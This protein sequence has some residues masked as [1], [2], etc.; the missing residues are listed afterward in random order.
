MKKIL[1]SIILLLAVF[2]L[3]SC[4]KSGLVGTWVCYDE[5][6]L[7]TEMYYVFK[8]DKTGKYSYYGENREFIYETKN[9]KITFKYIKNNDETVRDYKI[10]GDTLIIKDA[11]NNDVKYK[12]K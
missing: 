5:S 10:E 9:N 12:K 6:G 7:K 2:L 4:G 1:I 3:T 8:E 11:F